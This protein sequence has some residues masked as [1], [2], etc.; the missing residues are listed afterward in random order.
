M[1]AFLFPGIRNKSHYHLPGKFPGIQQGGLSYVGAN[2]ES[3]T[4]D[5]GLQLRKQMEMQMREE[6]KF[7]KSFNDYTVELMDVRNVTVGALA[8]ATGL[9]DHTIKNMRN[10]AD[11]MFPIQEIVAGRKP[12]V[13]GSRGTAAH[14]PD[15][16]I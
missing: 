2:G 6:A 4:T 1:R 9:S 10:K 5:A 12:S 7:E 13:G 16:R 15:G 11:I 8:E 3:V 14:E